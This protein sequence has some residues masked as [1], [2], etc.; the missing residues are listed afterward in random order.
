MEY[1][2]GQ[3]RFER[4]R[5]EWGGSGWG[6]EVDRFRECYRGP[7]S[8]KKARE[9]LRKPGREGEAERFREC[10]RR[11]WSMERARE[12]LRGPGKGGKSHEGVERVT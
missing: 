5:K 7:L 10:Y 11:P 3:D 9:V 8:M 2:K 4:T 1:G 12:N 6:G